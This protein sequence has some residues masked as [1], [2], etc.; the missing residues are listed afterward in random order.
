MS[1]IAASFGRRLCVS[2]AACVL[3]LCGG[4]SAS[5]AKPVFSGEDAA[6]SGTS[7]V[8]AA[9]AGWGAG[10]E[11]V[12]PANAVG[13]QAFVDSVS[14]PSA[15]NCSAVGSFY[16]SS[17]KYEGLLM[18][19]TAGTWASGVAAV[20]PANANPNPGVLLNSVSCASAGNCSAV[21]EYTDSSG[22]VQGLLLTETAGSWATGVEAVLPANATPN[23]GAGLD[24]VSCA[25]AGNCSAA[26]LYIDSS[27]RIHGLLLTETAGTWSVGEEPTLPANASD[28]PEVT[29]SSV[30]CASAGNCGAVGHYDS[31]GGCQA[32]LLTETAGTWATGVG[33][34]PADASG[35]LTASISCPS[36]GN[37]SAA[38]DRTLL[39]ETVGAWATG[40][41][42]VLP[43]NACPV[44]PGPGQCDS[45][46]G[47]TD[48]ISCASVGNCVA[49]G[50][51]TDSS[52]DGQGLLLTET[53][54]TWGAG[55]EAPLPVNAK[56]SGG[57]LSSVSCA[58]AGNCVAVGNYGSGSAS[59]LLLT[60]TAGQW[61][62]ARAALPANVAGYAQ[63]NSVSCASAGN[64]SAVGEYTDSS[65]N[66]HGVLLDSHPLPP[67]L[68]PKLKGK[69]LS[70]ARRSIRSHACSVGRTKHTASQAIKR[71]HVISQKPKP[72]KRLPHG[73]RVS[74]LVSRGRR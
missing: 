64:C 74:L 34:L 3:V 25:S 52:G 50:E 1:T 59:G 37:C 48:S 62:A 72:G 22:I 29:L 49:L 44:G 57:A 4:V 45:A 71:G 18:T 54:G 67:C 66:Y 9:R 8:S 39:T 7:A 42:T 69:T 68:V 73:A 17:E 20:L 6:S 27:N 10:V 47:L 53:A 41:E 38:A 31:S 60:E 32:L 14:C 70:A 13:D 61:T 16:D 58:S 51:Y 19:E 35:C 28:Q 40:V 11:A 46:G 24:S 15:G 55:V 5:A 26:G 56:S 63:L 43:A 65:G 33:A 30:S 21:G 36:A 2:A 23:E 12:L